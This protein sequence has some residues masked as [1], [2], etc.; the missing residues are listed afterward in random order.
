MRAT[1]GGGNGW[2]KSDWLNGR[3]AG[4]LVYSILLLVATWTHTFWRD[5][6][7]PWLIASA[8]PNLIA[9]LH[10]ARYE[11]HPPL[12]LT[13]THLAKLRSQKFSFRRK[14]FRS[15]GSIDM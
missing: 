14:A 1:D 4:I 6:S 8:S 3:S 12:K 5:E 9:L 11:G 10:N 2:R 13:R 7:E 15:T